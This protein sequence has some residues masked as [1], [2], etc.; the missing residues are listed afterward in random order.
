VSAVTTVLRTRATLVWL[1]LVVAT[2]VSWALGTEGIGDH[3]VA[4][5]VILGVALFKVRLVGLWF[6]QLRD[7]PAVLRGIFEV[8]CAVVLALTIGLF[9]LV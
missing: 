5:V 2:T 8:Y 4:S 7:A 9:L 3:R 1:A 6:M